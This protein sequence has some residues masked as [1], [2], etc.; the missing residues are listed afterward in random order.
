M[1]RN[2]VL[3][4]LALLLTVSTRAQKR[5]SREYNNV[6]ISDALNGLAEEQNDYAIMF[7]Y[8]ELEDFRITTTIRRKTLPEAIQQMIGFYPIRMT[9]DTSDPEDMKIFVECTHK[10]DR[11]LTGTIIDE[12]GQPVAYA[13]IAILNP[14]DSTLLGGGVSNESGYFVVP[15]EAHRVILKCSFVGYRTYYR[16]CEVGHIGTI[17]MKPAEYTINGVTVEGTRIMNYVDKSVHTFSVEQISQARNI[18]D[19]LEHVKDLKIDPVTNKIK[20]MDGGSVKILINGI[21]SS[22]ID[23]KGIPANKIVRVE[24]YNIPPARYADA[25]TLINVIT[26]RMD[27]GINAGIEARTA[28][29]TGFTDDEAYLNLTSGNHQLSLSY[30][31][32]LRDYTKR[33][34]ELTYDYT[35]QS[36]LPDETSSSPVH[37]NYQEKT[38]DKFG[39]TWN[40]P[41][42]KYTYNKPENIA[43]QIVATPHFNNRHSDGKKDIQKISTLHTSEIGEGEDGSRMS[44]FGP[45]LNVY[46]QKTLP[47][48]QE[49]SIDLVGTYYHNSSKNWDEERSVSNGE[50]WLSDNQEQQ[51][52]KYSFI[53]ELAY[54]KKWEKNSLSL[55]YRGTF[56][57][58]NA[59]ISNVLSN[60]KDYDYSSASYQ[61][62]MYAEYSGNI[63]KLMYRIGAGVTQVT[64]DNTDAHDSHWLFTPKL[65][66]S[67][68]LSKKMSLQWVTSSQSN[69]PPISQLS[70]NASLVIP[71]V[72]SIGNPYLKSYNT[73]QSELIHKW[74]LGWLQT[75]LGLY[76]AYTDSPINRYYTQQEINGQQYIVG[77]NENANH[78]SEL[79][80]SYLLVVS[81]FKSQILTL[82]L[83]GYVARQNVSSPIIGH[84]HHTWAPLYFA[85]QFRK[86]NW[87]ASYVGNIVSKRLNGSTLDAE[88]NSSHLQIY[89]QKKNWRI[90][91]ADYWLFTRSRYSGYSMPTSI[92]QSTYKTWIDDNKSMFILGFS[93]DFSTGK[94]LKINRKLQN[95]DSDTGSF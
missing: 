20:R 78:S 32:S 94:N 24:Y 47:K 95:K 18:R 44:T 70:N 12:Q 58:S 34:G 75:Q 80:G 3:I 25:G 79:G 29:T 33:F 83:Q 59:T 46:V 2:I 53:G 4:L 10:T 22:D 11:H 87:G 50:T 30:S 19:L 88:E 56:G 61:H 82:I 81:P 7:L 55:G 35:L 89:W 16:S 40:D 26:K 92:L 64:Q 27:T 66:L 74:N 51:N 31:F 8:N 5:I 63:S 48:N 62:Y 60:Y 71:G 39:Y 69:T 77:T 86:G 38:H 14:V 93:Y 6:S 52:N 57:R 67:T 42:I 72:L 45:N 15:T 13:N 91:A 90:F 84:Y 49:L 23:L 43:V 17:Q 54:T 41:V 73:Y 85:L 21:A 28:I 36:Y 76:Y 37:Y 1:N 9:V 68:N 65:I